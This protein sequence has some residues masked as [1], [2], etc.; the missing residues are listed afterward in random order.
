MHLVRFNK[1]NIKDHKRACKI[2][3][4]IV[5]KFGDYYLPIFER[6]LKELKIAEASIDLRTIA[7]QMAND[8]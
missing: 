5:A 2:A 3:A 6:T 8:N 4:I 1:L 7:L